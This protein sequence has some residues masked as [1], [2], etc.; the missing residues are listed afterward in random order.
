MIDKSKGL[1]IFICDECEDFY[2]TGLRKFQDAWDKAKEEGWVA[3]HLGN[4]WKHW[5][6][7]CKGDL[8]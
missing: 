2:E 3:R 7:D 8:E 4:E 6:P 5:C 1:L